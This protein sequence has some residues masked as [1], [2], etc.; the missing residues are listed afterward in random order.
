ML[1]NRFVLFLHDIALIIIVVFLLQRS[2]FLQTMAQYISG[3]KRFHRGQ[4]TY[5]TPLYASGTEHVS[6]YTG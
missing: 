4:S 1:N 2:R 3:S 6:D 5:L